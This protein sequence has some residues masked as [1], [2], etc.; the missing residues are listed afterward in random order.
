MND[1]DLNAADET[2]GRAS[3]V[4]RLAA[5]GPLAEGISHELHNPLNGA[6]LQLAVLQQRV[7][8][9]G[10]RPA[11]LKP[12][13]KRVEQALRRLERLLNELVCFARSQAERA[14]P[15]GASRSEPP[16]RGPGRG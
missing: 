4:E 16:P 7:E 14:P 5:L 2:A 1:V 3:L 9:P 15:A 13:A 12:V 6:L 8:Q 10:C 11:T